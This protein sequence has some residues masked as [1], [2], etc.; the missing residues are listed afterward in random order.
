[1]IH[2]LYRSITI[3]LTKR[4]EKLDWIWCMWQ[5]VWYRIKD[6]PFLV[7]NVSEI[8]ILFV[9]WWCLFIRSV[10]MKENVDCLS[11]QQNYLNSKKETS[12]AFVWISFPRKQLFAKQSFLS[13]AS[14]ADKPIAVYKATQDKSR[15]STVRVKVELGLLAIFHIEW[16]FNMSTKKQEKV[17]S[18]LRSLY[19]IICRLIGTFESNESECRL[20][21]GN[22]AARNQEEASKT[23][24]QSRCAQISFR[25][26]KFN[27]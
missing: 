3:F 10:Y 12:I 21:L 22:N 26:S 24:R 25:G 11:A 13:F 2:N 27:H 4:W 18:N 5:T 23:L 15:P 9:L 17:W 1:M 14:A 19:W 7:S 20:L 16:E 8:I 6:V